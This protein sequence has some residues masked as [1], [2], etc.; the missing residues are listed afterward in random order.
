MAKKKRRQRKNSVRKI[1]SLT[2]EQ[3]AKLECDAHAFLEVELLARKHLNEI[4]PSPMSTAYISL[5]TT[6]MTNLGMGF[7]LKLKAL[8]YK[9][10]GFIPCTHKFVKIYDSLDEG[11]IKTRLT[12]I[13]RE[14]LKDT[15]DRSIV[16]AYVFSKTQPSPLPSRQVRD[17]REFLSYLDEIGLYNRRYSFEEFSSREWWTEIRPTFLAQLINRITEFINSLPEPS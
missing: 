5:A 10:T 13:Y 2:K 7:E 14:C 17:F 9:A 6:I 11:S 12:E 1:T 3:F 8:H 4:Q 15:P 16:M